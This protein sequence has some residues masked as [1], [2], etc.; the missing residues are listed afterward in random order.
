[1]WSWQ[2]QRAPEAAKLAAYPNADWLLAPSAVPPGIRRDGRP[3]V[4][5]TAVRGGATS[6][7]RA[8]W[9]QY[10]LLRRL[11]SNFRCR[12]RVPPG[13]DDDAVAMVR[14]RVQRIELQRSLA[15]VDDVVVPPAGTTIA[16]PAADRR[17][18][19][20]EDRLACSLLDAEE[21]VELVDFRPI[22]SP[23]SRAMRTSW[24]FFAV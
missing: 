23:G 15:G 1:M 20:I 12:L 9:R 11:A 6:A 10:S 18:D 7:G 14:W 13:C 24:Q 16:K 8:A 19:A 5:T 21:L 2:R 4:Y 17:T 22:A 3:L